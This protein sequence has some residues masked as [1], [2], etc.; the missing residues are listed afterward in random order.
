MKNYSQNNEQ[1][2]ILKYF[3]GQTGVFLDIGANDG[4][5]FSNV[6]ALAELGWRGV[7]VE[8]SPKAFERLKANYE[9]LKGFYFYN[10]AIADHNGKVFLQESG[11]LVSKDDVALVSTIHQKEMKRF[12]GATQYESVEVPCLRWKTFINRPPLKD[13]DFITI[14][15]EGSE[16]DILPELDLTNTKMVCV[17]FNGHAHL[18]QEYEKYLTGFKLIYTSAENLIYAK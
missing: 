16:M 18:K 9:G 7:F 8:P 1:E 15:V 4:V 11:P 13:F 6:R 12:I 2:V 5:T 10:F 17:E 3:E 14:D